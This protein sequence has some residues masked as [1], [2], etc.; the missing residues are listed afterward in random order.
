M[1][2][3]NAVFGTL[4][5]FSLC[6]GVIV[7]IALTIGLVS[8]AE[9]MAS[10]GAALGGIG[11]GLI[12]CVPSLIFAGIGIL[13]KEK[14]LWPAVLGFILSVFPGGLGLRILVQILVDCFKHFLKI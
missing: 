1:K 8:G 12:A 5:L 10:L 4:S 14:P 6:A 11:F 7:G 2:Q 13:R 9:E 3:R